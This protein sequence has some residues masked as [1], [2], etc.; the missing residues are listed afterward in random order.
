[1]SAPRSIVRFGLGS[2]GAYVSLVWLAAAASLVATFA[3]PPLSVLP[4]FATLAFLGIAARHLR[5]NLYQRGGI[6]THVVVLIAA[7]ILLGPTL[8]MLLGVMIALLRWPW[9]SSPI[10]YVFDAGMNA[11]TVAIVALAAAPVRTYALEGNAFLLLP[12][13]VA[14]GAIAFVLNFGLLTGV[15]AISEQGSFRAIW[16]ERSSWLLPHFIAFGV[17]AL[18]MA[19]AGE[20]LGVAGL[21]IFAVPVVAMRVALHQYVEQTQE[22]LLALREANAQLEEQNRELESA[23][24]ATRTAFAGMLKARDDETEGHSERVVVY[25]LAIARELGLKGEALGALEVGALLHDIGKVGVSDA[26]LHKP[27]PLTPDEWTEMRRHPEIGYHLTEQI[28]FLRPAS[29]V[30]RHHHERW[31]GS[32]YP[33]GLKETSIPLGARIFALADTFD[34]MVSDRP[35]RKGLAPEIAFAEIGRGSGRQFD[36]AVV[37][38]F[39]AVT[40][41]G[42]WPGVPSVTDV[43]VN[44]TGGRVLFRRRADDWKSASVTA[45]SGGEEMPGTAP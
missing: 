33:D 36:P 20:M 24:A 28:P 6:S 41:R 38:A 9:K 16:H 5:I 21:L 31:D 32:G 4:A 13:G 42:E 37:D 39:L 1:M 14:L 18:G 17:L 11:V 12:V 19:R 15:M 2:V 7:A 23:H 26:I 25:A 44:A 40:R 43:M 10:H 29:P 3:V 27:G 34:A 30:V 45:E 35:Y 22:N 8:A